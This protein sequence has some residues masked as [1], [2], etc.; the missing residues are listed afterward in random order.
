MEKKIL[1]CAYPMDTIESLVI[2]HILS[3]FAKV[4]QHFH[5]HVRH[6]RRRSNLL[7]HWTIEEAL[8]LTPN[9]IHPIFS[10]ECRR[11]I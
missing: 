4:L 10:I 7:A 9:Y 6:S 8:Y 11:V 5:S 1:A 3:F 2:N